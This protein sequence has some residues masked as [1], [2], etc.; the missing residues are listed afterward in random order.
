MNAKGAKSYVMIDDNKIIGGAIIAINEETNINE[1]LILYVK[2]NCQSKGVGF[3]I[4][5]NI[6]KLYPKTKIWVSFL[7]KYGSV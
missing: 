5:N 7:D 2:V 3:N 1:L 6:E 4:W